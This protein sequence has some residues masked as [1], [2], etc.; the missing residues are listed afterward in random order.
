MPDCEVDAPQQK[1]LPIKNKMSE[2]QL[3]HIEKGGE[4]VTNG[5]AFLSD[6]RN[7]VTVSLLILMLYSPYKGKDKDRDV[8]RVKKA[9]S[10]SSERLACF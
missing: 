2:I 6:A 1:Q 10:E 8:N 5:T 7:C 9:E 3:K 4:N